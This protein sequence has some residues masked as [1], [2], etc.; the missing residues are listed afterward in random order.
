MDNIMLSNAVEDDKFPSLP[1]TPCK[2]LPSKKPNMNS[3]IVA[4]L[5]L[6][7]NSRSDATEKMVGGNTMV[8]KGLIKTGVCMW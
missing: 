4:T 7:I 3:D 6:L 1:V 5:S 2:P 8:I